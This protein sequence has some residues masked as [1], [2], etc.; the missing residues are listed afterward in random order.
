MTSHSGDAD[1]RVE[2]LLPCPFCGFLPKIYVEEERFVMANVYCD[3]DGC[4]NPETRLRA[5]ESVATADWNTRA[6]SVRPVTDAMIEKARN[7]Y[8]R[9]LYSENPLTNKPS[10][11]DRA[12]RAAIIAALEPPK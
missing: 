1:D 2:S 6:Q 7:T 3:T 12:F 5:N 9:S 8:L 10:A 4:L 11:E